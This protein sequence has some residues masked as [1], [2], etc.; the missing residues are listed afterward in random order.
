MREEGR[1]DETNHAT[2]DLNALPISRLAHLH[3][4]LLSE[5]VEERSIGEERRQV[6]VK[7]Y[8]KEEEEGK[9]DSYLRSF[10]L[11]HR[12]RFRIIILRE[13]RITYSDSREGVDIE[14]S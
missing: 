9:E 3:L 11:L 13:L 2:N 1:S 12:R 5:V 10:E 8:V 4:L 6:E 14:V 7:M